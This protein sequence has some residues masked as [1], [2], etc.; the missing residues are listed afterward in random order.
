MP[1]DSL[2]HRFC[3]SIVC[4]TDRAI[5]RIEL[6]DRFGR[7]TPKRRG[8][9]HLPN[10]RIIHHH[11]GILQQRQRLL[12]LKRD[13]FFVSCEANEQCSSVCRNAEFIRKSRGYDLCRYRKKT[14][15][16]NRTCTCPK[17]LAVPV[18]ITVASRA[19]RGR[20]LKFT[21]VM[22]PRATKTAGEQLAKIVASNIFHHSPA[23]LDHAAICE[24]NSHPD[25][26]SARAPVT[27]LL[28]AADAGCNDTSDAWRDR[29][30]EDRAV[31]IDDSL[32]ASH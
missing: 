26:R 9:N 23:G 19:G 16:Q 25:H 3:R 15:V 13:T 20:S 28:R 31:T 7:L 14:R 6:P 21:S 29:R 18:T 8:G 4:L 27:K 2:H 32:R 11:L 10:L 24:H 17:V 1:F 5:Q 12:S 22:I 30:P